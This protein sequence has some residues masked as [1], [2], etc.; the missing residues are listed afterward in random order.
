M[1]SKTLRLK[2]SKKS[3]KSNR[4]RYR[5]KRVKR[6]RSK[7]V[8]RTKIKKTKKSKKIKSRHAKIHTK[9]GKKKKMKGGT[10][11]W[12]TFPLTVSHEDSEPEAKQRAIAFSD[13]TPENMSARNHF[14]GVDMMRYMEVH[15]GRTPE[16]E[17]QHLQDLKAQGEGGGAP[18]E[19]G[20]AG[21]GADE[22]FRR[23]QIMKEERDIVLQKLKAERSSEYKRRNNVRATLGLQPLWSTNALGE[24]GGKGSG[25]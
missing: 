14:A 15:E 22:F 25:E 13:E 10:H 3:K 16:K 12:P 20:A 19:G 2:K 23:R 18:A 7:R 4:T 6:S 9:K 21:A 11:P 17:Y 24:G 1:R 8:K 5:S